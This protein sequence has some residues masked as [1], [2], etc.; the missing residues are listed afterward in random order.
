MSG[1][2]DLVFNDK[3]FK[4]VI[5]FF[6]FLVLGPDLTTISAGQWDGKHDCS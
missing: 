4:L 6:L 3:G 1:L 5:S 2:F